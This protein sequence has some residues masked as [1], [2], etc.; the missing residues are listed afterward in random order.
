MPKNTGKKS[1][2]PVQ[3]EAV[4]AAIREIVQRDFG[5]KVQPF[6][7]AIGV[8]QGFVSDVLNDKRGPGI[9]LLTAL[10]RFAGKSIE[11]LTGGASAEPPPHP[12]LR[13]ALERGG[14]PTWAAEA[15]RSR[16]NLSGAPLTEE[17]WRD[18]LTGLLAVDAM[19]AAKTELEAEYERRRAAPKRRAGK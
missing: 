10:S 11:E 5:G 2:P 15:A 19:S 14:W 17:Q 3:Q 4:K 18:W 8:S 6:A 12:T 9:S 7:K 13:A 1:L 16:Q